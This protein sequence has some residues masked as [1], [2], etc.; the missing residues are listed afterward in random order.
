MKGGV[1]SA[2]TVLEH[3]ARRG[4]TGV[5]LWLLCQECESEIS[6]GDFCK[7]V[8]FKGHGDFVSLTCPVCGFVMERNQ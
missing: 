6:Y 5:T 2:V 7:N 4:A 1:V 8:V 3:W